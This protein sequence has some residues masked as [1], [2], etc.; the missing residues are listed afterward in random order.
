MTTN[1]WVDWSKL[2]PD[3]ARSIY[4]DAISGPGSFDWIKNRYAWENLGYD[5]HVIPGVS[6]WLPNEMRGELAAAANMRERFR[7]PVGEEFHPDANRATPMERF[8]RYRKRLQYSAL[9]GG[10]AVGAARAWWQPVSNPTPQSVQEAAKRY[11]GDWDSG[12]TVHRYYPPRHVP[13]QTK[14][15][16]AQTLITGPYYAARQQTPRNF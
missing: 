11:S 1:A 8:D 13:H 12:A 5:G 6:G 2:P 10:A 3:V 14:S 4:K 16:Q 9:L 15:S 7:M